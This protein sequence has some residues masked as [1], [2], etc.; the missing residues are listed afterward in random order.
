MSKIYATSSYFAVFYVHNYDKQ[1][2]DCYIS[3]NTWEA[4]ADPENFNK[5]GWS[6][7]LFF[8]TVILLCKL[9]KFEF[10]RRC[11]DRGPF[12]DLHILRDNN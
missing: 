10:S 6:E 9:K 3:E 5:V 2:H 1:M 11:L 4:S 8:G 7:V 12:L